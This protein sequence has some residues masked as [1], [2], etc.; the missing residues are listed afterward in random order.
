[1]FDQR[2]ALAATSALI[3][4][5]LLLRSGDRGNSDH[6]R[7]ENQHDGSGADLK[8]NGLHGNLRILRVN[9]G[10]RS[11][12]V[13]TTGTPRAAP[14]GMKHYPGYAVVGYAFGA[15]GVGV[16]SAVPVVP[17]APVAPVGDRKVDS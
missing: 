9:S 12:V 3:S 7:D 15:S 13:G 14:D 2:L 11:H 17:D 6:Q 4:V 8:H 5:M 1:M 10:S 16:A